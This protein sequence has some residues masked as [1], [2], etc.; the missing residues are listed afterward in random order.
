MKIRP[1]LLPLMAVLVL[2]GCATPKVPEPP[3]AL[4]QPELHPEP[5]QI[6]GAIYQAGHDVRLYEDRIARRVGDLVTVLLEESTD[7]SKDARTSVSKSSNTDL[8]T[9]TVFGRPMTFNGNPFSADF[10]GSRDFEGEGAS[11]QSNALSGTVTAMVVQRM[12]NGN[13]VIQGQKQLTLNRGDEYVTIT[14]IVRPE[15]IQP[16]NTVSSTRVANARLSYIGRGELADANS[17]GWLSR[18]FNSPIWPF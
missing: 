18:F 11:A 13:L 8:P 1:A 6:N 15:D 12:P 17:M 9:P 14:G 16:D 7:A 2:A 5:K 3:M 10:G 4:P